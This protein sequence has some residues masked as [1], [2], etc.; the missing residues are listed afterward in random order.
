MDDVGVDRQNVG[1][2]QANLLWLTVRMVNDEGRVSLA[3]GEERPLHR[4]RAIGY[5]GGVL[6]PDEGVVQTTFGGACDEQPGR[7][8]REGLRR[9]WCP[10][11]AG[12]QA[13]RQYLVIELDLGVSSH[14]YLIEHM[15]VGQEQVRADQNPVPLQNPC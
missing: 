1:V 7:I 15:V 13:F 2:V 5:G 6:D 4:Y 10:A 11:V 8:D 9:L 14:L 3:Y 12:E